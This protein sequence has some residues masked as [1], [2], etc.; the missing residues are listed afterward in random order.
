MQRSLAPLG[1]QSESHV[2]FPSLVE[3]KYP[4]LIQK[5]CCNDHQT[6]MM[7]GIKMNGLERRRETEMD[8]EIGH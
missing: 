5:L 4:M 6:E 7:S 1:C 8:E 3:I 2:V